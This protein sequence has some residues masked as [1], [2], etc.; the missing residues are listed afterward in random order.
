MMIQW[1]HLLYIAVVRCKMGKKGLSV[2]ELIVSFVLCILVFVFIIQVVS[3]VEELYI[4]LGIKTEL[5]NKQSLISE[6]INNRLSK[7]DVALIKNCGTNC[8]TFFYKN[9]TSEKMTIDKEKNIF[10]FGTISYSFSG[11]G[12]VDSL[13]INTNADA[14]YGQGILSIN[15]NVKNSIFD[16]GKY[17]IKALYQYNTSET[18]YSA[19]SANKPEIIL[20]GPATNYKFTEDLFVETGWIVYYPDGTITIN[21]NDVIP[22]E[23]Q[24]DDDGNAYVE[25]K[26]AGKAE[27]EETTR[28]IKVYTTAKEHIIDLAENNPTSGVHL[29]DGIGKYVYKGANPDNY[30]SIGSKLFRIMSLDI[31]SQYVLDSNGEVLIENGDKVKEDKYLLKVVSED[32]ITDSE[33]NSIMP[34]GNARNG[35]PLFNL[36]TWSK[37]ICTDPN[38]KTTCTIYRQ[39]INSIVND[40]W[41]QGLLN[42]GTGR[43]QIKNGT[44]NSGMIDWTKYYFGPNASN[45]TYTYP[46]NEVYTLEGTDVIW[47]DGVTIEPGKWHGDCLEDVCEPNAGIYSVTDVLLASSDENCYDAI[48]STMSGNLSVSCSNKNWLWKKANDGIYY[49]LMTRNTFTNTWLL[50]G[51]NFLLYNDVPTEYA[52]RGTLYL[53]ANLYIMGAGT[54]DSPYSLYSINK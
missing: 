11:L 30:I 13:T 48:I 49:R 3:S 28:F 22:S 23:V 16:T 29:Y 1:H 9:N 54:I 7:S 20:L 33:G 50:T 14:S 46:I 35:E 27:G 53:D 36:S 4:N 17:I 34:F 5:L 44:F 8:L 24:Y 25:Y 10:T 6:D 18:V 15:L 37:T 26:G 2:V 43:L 45:G 40:I 38:D 41:L 12:F 32:Y 19:S 31:Q 21:E 42:T 47:G 39:Y 51:T 52:T